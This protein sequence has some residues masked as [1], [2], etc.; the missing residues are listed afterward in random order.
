MTSTK[1]KFPMSLSA[2]LRIVVISAI[3]LLTLIAGCKDEES[4]ITPPADHFQPEGLMLRAEGDTVLYY[5]QGAV[6]P[7]DTIKA[8]AGNNLSP[9]FT[10]TFL[11]A[12]GEVISP[13]STSTHHLGWTIGLNNVAEVYRDPGDE[14]NF[15]VRGKDSGYTTITLRVLHGD[16]ADFT[17][18]ALPLHVSPLF[19]GEA[20]GVMLIDEESGDTLAM[21]TSMGTTGSLTVPKDSTTDHMVVYFLDAEG[22]RFQPPVP[23][24][25]LG[26][27]VLNTSVAELLPAGA[28][29]PWA[30]QLRGIAAGTTGLRLKLLAEGIEE[31]VAP[32][33]TLV[34][35]P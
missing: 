10:L 24:H 6:R 18:Q 13:P 14:W 21:A 35:T 1:E 22:I 9:H 5:F 31:Y 28:A 4:P 16:H 29:E 3:V 7:G 34:V 27:Q 23:P 33:I 20:A 8:P 32:D 30:F 2:S 11:N 26:Y 15:H 19:V 12:A 17:T 25:S